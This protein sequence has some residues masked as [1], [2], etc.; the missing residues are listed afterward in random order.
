MCERCVGPDYCRV[1]RCPNCAEVKP[2]APT[3]DYCSS[4]AWTCETCGDQVSVTLAERTLQTWSQQAQISS[5]EAPTKP[6]YR[7]RNEAVK[8]LSPTHFVAIQTWGQ[9]ARLYASKAAHTEQM[10]SMMLAM[11]RPVMA[12]PFNEGLSKNQLRQYAAIAGLRTIALSECVASGCT[13]CEPGAFKHTPVYDCATA[14]FHACIDLVG[15]PATI[16]PPYA[17]EMVTRYLAAMRGQ[18]GA[19][20][21]DVQAIENKLVGTHP[22]SRQCDGCGKTRKSPLLTCVRCKLF[23]Y[24]TKDCQVKHWKRAHKFH[25]MPASLK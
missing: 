7:V 1:A 21:T 5:A 2:C 25:C 22:K 16:R 14:M 3:T 23:Y 17:M 18:F 11:R 19:D 20:D 10:E 15:I 6:L 8:Q 4:P 9:L 24:C 12:M 13:G